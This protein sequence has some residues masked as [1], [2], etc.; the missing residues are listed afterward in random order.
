M[1]ENVAQK[2]ITAFST[3]NWTLNNFIFNSKFYLQVKGF[4]VGTMRTPSYANTFRSE[5][6]E[7][8]ICLLIKNKSIS[9]IY[10]RFTDDILRYD[11]NKKINLNY[12]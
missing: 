8:Y 2:I 9:F 12:L 11:P 1:E 4:T 7:I 5:F 3:F 10:F 6:K